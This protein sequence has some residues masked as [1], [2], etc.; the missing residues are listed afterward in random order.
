MKNYRD[1]ADEILGATIS[2]LNLTQEEL[3]GFYDKI[4]EHGFT[5]EKIV[6]D[7]E[8]SSDYGLTVQTEQRLLKLLMMGLYNMDNN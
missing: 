4:E 3:P 7:L 1:L 6:S 8:H 2:E 5:K